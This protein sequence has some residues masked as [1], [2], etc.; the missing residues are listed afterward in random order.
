MAARD[1]P[2][3]F[4]SLLL[5]SMLHVPVHKVSTLPRYDVEVPKTLA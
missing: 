4:C 1:G 5:Y 3:F 2:V